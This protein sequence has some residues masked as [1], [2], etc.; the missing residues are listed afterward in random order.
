MPRASGIESRR[1]ALR[2]LDQ[3][4]EGKPLDLAL[5]RGIGELPDADRRLAHELAAGVLRH[6][7]V[8]DQQ[9]APLVP[10]GWTSVSPR[11]QD[12]LRLGAYQLTNLQRVPSH[13]AVDTSV[14]LAKV[15]GGARAGG[16]VN[17]V[18]RRLWAIGAP[19]ASTSR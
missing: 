17:A 13:A 11:L 12:V 14:A 10:R 8:L 16:F 19:S 7:S 3:V 1:A 15:V 9:L 18:L 5:D 2:V 4:R 6:R